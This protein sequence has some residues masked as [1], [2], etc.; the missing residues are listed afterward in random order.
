MILQ[1]EGDNTYND[2]LKL[3]KQDL[4]CI[5][6]HLVFLSVDRFHF[7]SEQHSL[8]LKQTVYP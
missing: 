1:Q 5:L 3:P 6:S 8:Y 2:D 4:M 7:M